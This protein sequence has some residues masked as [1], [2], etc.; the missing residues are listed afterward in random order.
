[1]SGWFLK[2]QTPI[3]GCYLKAMLTPEPEAERTWWEIQAEKEQTEDEIRSRMNES[4]VYKDCRA[5][6]EKSFDV[7]RKRVKNLEATLDSELLT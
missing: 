2:P 1:M 7:E 5:A 3:D 6:I 4:F